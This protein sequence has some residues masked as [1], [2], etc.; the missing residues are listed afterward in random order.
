M[1]CVNS[2]NPDGT[3]APKV[4]AETR[5]TEAREKPNLMTPEKLAELRVEGLR[6]LAEGL[7]ITLT[8]KKKAGMIEEILAAVGDGAEMPAEV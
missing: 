1:K 8:A 6:A 2:A 5:K 3:R 7:G 4:K